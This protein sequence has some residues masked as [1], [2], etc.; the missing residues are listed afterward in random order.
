M[1]KKILLASCLLLA[2]NSK[3]SAIDAIS[4]GYGQGSPASLA[5]AMLGGKWLWGDKWTFL[6]NFHAE[7]FW[8]G[9]LAYWTNDGSSDGD[10][11]TLFTIAAAP[12]LR[13]VYGD[14]VQNGIA[15]YLDISIGPAAY[16]SDRLANNRL[17]TIFGFEQ[18]YGGGVE[19]GIDGQFDLS[20][21][22]V[23]Y[24]NFG[25]FKHND[26]FKA[27][28]MITFAYHFSRIGNGDDANHM[29]DSSDD[30]YHY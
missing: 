16:S 11:K 23:S 19:F 7:G 13:L 6:K 10:H 24:S 28:W 27:P 2:L 12:E 18:Q 22:Y 29:S 26:G 3:A 14:P 30:D 17:G 20:Y 25:I 4:L 8:A 9:N 5:G 1:L 21:H 15:Y